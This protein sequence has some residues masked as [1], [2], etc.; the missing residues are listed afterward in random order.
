MIKSNKITLTFDSEDAKRAWIATYLDGGGQDAMEEFT[1]FNTTSWTD[2]EI[3]IE[4]TGE[5]IDEVF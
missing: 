5:I 3:T 4:G 2:S 1:D